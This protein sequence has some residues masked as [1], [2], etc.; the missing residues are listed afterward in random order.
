MTKFRDTT[1]EDSVFWPKLPHQPSVNDLAN[2]DLPEAAASAGD[3]AA[4]PASE[5]AL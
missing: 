4:F 5:S 1:I 2:L 3:K